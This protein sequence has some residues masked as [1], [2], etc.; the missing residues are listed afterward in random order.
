VSDA[1]SLPIPDDG[2]LAAVEAPVVHSGQSVGAGP[3]ERALD[4]GVD[5]LVIEGTG[6][7]NVTAALGDA[8]AEV[9]VVVATRSPAGRTGQVYG[10][11]GGGVTLRDHG[12]QFAGDRSASTARVVLAVALAGGASRDRIATLFA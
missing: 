2:A 9:P 5:G 4:A 10:T 7:G 6:L 1:P 12:M 8:V 11:P 3:I